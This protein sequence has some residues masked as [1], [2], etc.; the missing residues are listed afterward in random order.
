MSFGI[1]LTVFSGDFDRRLYYDI[2]EAES[3]NLSSLQIETKEMLNNIS[4]GQ[5]LY[6]KS[7]TEKNFENYW[8]VDECDRRSINISVLKD[9]S[10]DTSHD[11]IAYDEIKSVSDKLVEFGFIIGG[12]IISNA[13][14]LGKL[15]S[16]KTREVRDTDRTYHNLKLNPNKEIIMKEEIVISMILEGTD[17][18]RYDL[19]NEFTDSS[20]LSYEDFIEK[21][22]P[23]KWGDYS[24]I[25][26]KVSDIMLHGIDED[27]MLIGARESESDPTSLVGFGSNEHLKVMNVKAMEKVYLSKG[28]I[29][30]NVRHINMNTEEVYRG[31]EEIKNRGKE[32]MKM[33]NLNI[34]EMTN[35][36][37][38]V[39]RL[40]ET[41]EIFMG[42]SEHIIQISEGSDSD[43]GTINLYQKKLYM[44]EE[45]GVWENGGIDFKNIEEFDVWVSDNIDRIIPT[46][47]G[48]V[49]MQPRRYSKEDFR[50]S[51]LMKDIFTLEF[52]KEMNSKI[53]IILRNGSNVYRIWSDHIKVHNRL[54]PLQEELD[55]IIDKISKNERELN[56]NLEYY[57]KVYGEKHLLDSKDNLFFYIRN[58]LLLQGILSRTKVFGFVPDN[59][60]ILNLSEH[61]D[62]IK[63]IYNDDDSISIGDG[64]PSFDE[65]LNSVN[66]NMRKGKKVLLFPTYSNMSRADIRDRYNVYMDEYSNISLPDNGVYTIKSEI[67][68][69]EHKKVY[70]IPEETFILNKDKY[71]SAIY[72]RRDTSIIDGVKHIRVNKIDAPEDISYTTSEELYITFF[73]DDAYGKY[74]NQWLRFNINKDDKFLICYE[75]IDDDTL[76]YYTTDREARRKY[77]LVLPLLERFKEE[78]KKDLIIHKHYVDMVHQLL[79]DIDLSY[80]DK[81]EAINEAINKWKN[82]NKVYDNTFATLKAGSV[83]EIKSIKIILNESKRLLKKNHKIDIVLNINSKD[84]IQKIEVR[85]IKYYAIGMTKK[86]FVDKVND[87]LYNSVTKKK[88]G[89]IC[90]VVIDRDEIDEL[91]PQLTNN[92]IFRKI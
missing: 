70:V 6:Y 79:K 87:I 40:I 56:N 21:Y 30:F 19:V 63:Y 4:L 84:K 73:Q 90:N 52:E 17:L 35:K 43:S 89:V 58:F 22:N 86:E 83:E 20:E 8:V 45:I 53:Y 32:M 82:G 61:E 9:Y 28:I 5:I 29:K 49:M 77:L 67:I 75:D 14:I 48:V 81:N 65:W 25:C 51:P 42:V 80:M 46:D 24:M 2:L 26:E 59:F 55:K 18:K 85:G 1:S 33:L 88:L 13:S 44:D 50:D 16:V 10:V 36:V 72:G 3:K 31:M 54:F 78:K 39:S 23:L 38:E 76:D 57:E 91:L 62:V 27:Q 15:I 74:R 37:R 64:L 34:L 47:T 92:Q 68:K 66:K 71:V 7:N 41:I 12:F 11:K 60:N 69:T